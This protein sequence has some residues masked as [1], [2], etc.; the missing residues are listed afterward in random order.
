M[1]NYLPSSK[2]TLK[3]IIENLDLTNDDVIYDLGSGDGRV[4]IELIKKG[5]KAKGIEKDLE[6]IKISKILYKLNNHLEFHENFKLIF[7]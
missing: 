2:E 6:L 3:L 1:V 7:T 4:V 5:F